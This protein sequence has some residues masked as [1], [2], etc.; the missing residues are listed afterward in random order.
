MPEL[1]NNLPS[2]GLLDNTN[3]NSIQERADDM[4]DYNV[5][6]SIDQ[7]IAVVKIKHA[8][9]FPVDNQTDLDTFNAA[10]ESEQVVIYKEWL[11]EIDSYP[12]L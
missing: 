9:M 6:N 12:P 11:T 4:N 3:V 1:L 2:P 7:R 8:I 5:D 10:S